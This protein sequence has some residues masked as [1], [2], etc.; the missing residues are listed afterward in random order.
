MIDDEQGRP[1]A[2]ADRDLRELLERWARWLSA[3]SSG[4]SSPLAAAYDERTDQTQE[5]YRD[6]V[7]EY[8]DQRIAALSSPQKRVVLELY[9]RGRSLREAARVIGWSVRVIE[10]QN[11]AAVSFLAGGIR[12]E[13]G[14][15]ATVE[16]LERWVAAQATKA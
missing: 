1:Q 16:N 10:L 13:T 15:P 2:G 14:H 9:Y 7:A 6:E 4:L 5:D 3:G 8:L 11:L 12:A